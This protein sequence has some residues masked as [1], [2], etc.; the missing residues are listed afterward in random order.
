LASIGKTGGETGNFTRGSERGRIVGFAPP[1]PNRN[2]YRYQLEH[3]FQAA[4]LPA[5]VV[6]DTKAGHT[7][8][9]PVA[10]LIAQEWPALLDSL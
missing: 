4:G 1:R 3:L 7:Y 10:G 6:A 8:D 2:A 9:D 5:S